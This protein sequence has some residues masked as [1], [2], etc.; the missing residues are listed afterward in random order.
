MITNLDVL[1]DARTEMKELRKDL[2]KKN[3]SPETREILIE[4]VALTQTIINQSEDEIRKGN[5]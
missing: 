2:K 3:L 5:P 1:L 4:C